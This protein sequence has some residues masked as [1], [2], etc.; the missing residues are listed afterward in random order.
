MKVVQER[1]LSKVS[2]AQN[3]HRPLLKPSCTKGCTNCDSVHGR[4]ISE[5]ALTTSES[6]RTN[7][8]ICGVAAE[9]LE[10]PMWFHSLWFRT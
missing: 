10:S 4:K 9:T 3:D 6:R 1:G 2:C 5:T 7:S 8:T